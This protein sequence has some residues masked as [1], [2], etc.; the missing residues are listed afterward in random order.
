MQVIDTTTA[1]VAGRPGYEVWAKFSSVP[2]YKGFQKFPQLWQLQSVQRDTPKS[3]EQWSA[4]A[5]SGTTSKHIRFAGW[6]RQLKADLGELLRAARIVNVQ[7]FEVR[8]R[9]RRPRPR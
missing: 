5:A 3:G 4:K 1:I 7:H 8:R 2:L 9:D 6:G